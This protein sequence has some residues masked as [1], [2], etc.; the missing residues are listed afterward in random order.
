MKRRDWTAAR[1]KVD[2]EGECRACGARE[3]SS[4]RLE[5]SHLWPRSLGGTQH[6]DGIIPLCRQFGRPGCHDLFDTHRLNVGLVLTTDEQAELVRQ[7]GSLSTAMRRV[8]P[9]DYRERQAA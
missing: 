8:Y 7:C 5:A 4:V 6:A 3:S 9:I 2:D 1:A